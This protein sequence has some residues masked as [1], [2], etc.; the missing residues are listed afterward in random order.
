[1]NF[2]TYRESVLDYLETFEYE[3]LVVFYEADCVARTIGK[4]IQQCYA[5]DLSFRICAIIIWSLTM[6]EK[7]IPESKR[8]VKN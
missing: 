2:P 1:M 8:A 6:T 4:T 3:N 5:H 7:I